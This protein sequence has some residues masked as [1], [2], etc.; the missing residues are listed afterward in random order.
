MSDFG[1]ALSKPP[2]LTLLEEKNCFK[3]KTSN[4]HEWPG[5]PLD[6][7]KSHKFS[8]SDTKVFGGAQ[9]RR[10][11]DEFEVVSLAL[12]FPTLSDDEILNVSSA[13]SFGSEGC[14]YSKN[15]QLLECLAKIT[16]RKAR[17]CFSPL[18]DHFVSR[19]KFV[20]CDIIVQDLS[21]KLTTEEKKRDFVV[22]NGNN[23]F[24]DDPMHKESTENEFLIEVSNSSSEY[25][26]NVILPELRKKVFCEL[27]SFLSVLDLNLFFSSWFSSNISKKVK[28]TNEQQEPEYHEEEQISK[29]KSI[30][31]KINERLNKTN[32]F[33]P[34]FSSTQER[35]SFI[36]N[37]CKSIFGALRFIFSKIVETNFT[38]TFVEDLPRMLDESLRCHFGGFSDDEL[39]KKFNKNF[40][41][42]Q[43]Q[44]GIS[45][46]ILNGLSEHMI[47]VNH[48]LE[49]NF[50]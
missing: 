27:D 8:N 28:E 20:L 47:N 34:Q 13:I 43:Q 40:E 18:L 19:L 29:G 48:I 31:S 23:S 37:S 1:N 22:D 25:I 7:M 45:H 5:V 16:C 4:A 42:Y 2:G 14:V 17:D 30:S 50:I 44:R 38:I 12:H 11:F 10:I 35:L 24:I 3:Q 9:I 41:F 32:S 6:F 36:R 15:S 39:K 26:S 49:L 33:S 21:L 46:G